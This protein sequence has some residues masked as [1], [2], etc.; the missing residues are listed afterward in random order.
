M[1]PEADWAARA[2]NPL[3]RT[4]LQRGWRS[5]YLLRTRRQKC[6]PGLSQSGLR[7]LCTPVFFCAQAGL[8]FVPQAP[9]A[10]HNKGTHPRVSLTGSSDPPHPL[11]AWGGAFSVG[12]TLRQRPPHPKETRGMPKGEGGARCQVL[13]KATTP[14]VLEAGQVLPSQGPGPGQPAASPQGSPCCK[15]RDPSTNGDRGPQSGGPPTAL[16]APLPVERGV[17][18]APTNG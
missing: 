3:P 13:P 8:G 4:P 17:G 15:P 2:G 9:A 18:G 7:P 10:Q 11:L 1:G 16:P 12:K 6:L 5:P 14:C